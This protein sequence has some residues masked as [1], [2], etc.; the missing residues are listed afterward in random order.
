MGVGNKTEEKIA[1]P[2][3]DQARH[4]FTSLAKIPGGTGTYL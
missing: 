1:R 2:S 4:W 3:L